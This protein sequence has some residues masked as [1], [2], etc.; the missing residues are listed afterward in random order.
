MLEEVLSDVG[1]LFTILN[2][3]MRE[4]SLMQVEVFRAREVMEGQLRLE[5]A[6]YKSQKLQLMKIIEELTTRV[7]DVKVERERIEKAKEV[8]IENERISLIL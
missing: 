8:E 2:D 4:V 7:G 3:R 5:R 1:R 6:S